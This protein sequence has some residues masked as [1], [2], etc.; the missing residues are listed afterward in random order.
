MATD[1]NS[2][3]SESLKKIQILVVE[4][5]RIIGIN[6]KENLESLG[7]GVPT[8]TD[9]GE[10]A[11]QKAAQLHPDLVLIDIQLKGDMDGIETAQQIWEYLQ[12][13]V[14]YLTGHA[15]K[16]TVERAKVSAAFGYIL[17]PVKKQELYMAI[18]T[19][20]Q[21]YEREQ[22]L[23]VA[24]QWL[25]TLLER[26]ELSSSENG[27]SSQSTADYPTSLQNQSYQELALVNDL[28]NRGAIDTN[29][30]LLQSTA[31]QLQ[32]WIPDIVESFQ[33][34]AQNQQQSLQLRL[35]LDL[36]PLISDLSSLT[37]IVSELL[38][39]AC[40]YTPAGEQIVVAVR[41]KLGVSSST[42]CIQI[43]ISNSGVEI[44]QA[45]LPHIF[46]PFYCIPNHDPWQ[47]GGTGLGLAWVAKLVNRLQGNVEVTSFEGWTTFMIEIPNLE[48]PLQESG[49]DC[50]RQ[51]PPNNQLP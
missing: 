4:D 28:L 18:E 14:I 5:E 8:I 49:D 51:N 1:T 36:P 22:L 19:A 10:Q 7:Y 44:P 46:R 37:R 20:L 42:P 25:R 31:I 16:S 15:D 30:Y 26:Q 23:R 9:S 40:K 24:V 43:S 45:E 2:P 29:P 12:I 38:N 34:R 41:A 27:L 39:N 35:P 11:I 17:K 13:P 33:S 48:L 6:L 32:E 3:T 50:D 21:H 47:Q